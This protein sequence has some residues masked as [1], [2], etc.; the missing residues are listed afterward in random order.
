MFKQEVEAVSEKYRNMDRMCVRKRKLV[1][2]GC[3]RCAS[4]A[5][6]LYIIIKITGKPAGQT[7]EGISFDP[8]QA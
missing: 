4:K 3:H 8:W 2:R 5:T 1:L 7:S 6:G